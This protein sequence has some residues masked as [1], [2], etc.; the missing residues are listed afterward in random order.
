MS[1]TSIKTK[2]G[3]RKQQQQPVLSK[4]VVGSNLPLLQPVDQDQNKVVHELHYPANLEVAQ[5]K[6][7]TTVSRARNSRE[8][9]SRASSQS[10]FMRQQDIDKTVA[11]RKQMKDGPPRPGRQERATDE[12]VPK[13]GEHDSEEDL[14][15]TS[16]LDSMSKNMPSIENRTLE[17]PRQT[18]GPIGFGSEDINVSVK[19]N[20]GLIREPPGLNLYSPAKL[21]QG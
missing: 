1:S 10:N 6:T 13:T 20:D 12:S 4:G 11:T 14:G 8:L 16:L 21:P 2:K 9:P 19:K 3:K 17:S 18:M 7:P 5:S 15:K